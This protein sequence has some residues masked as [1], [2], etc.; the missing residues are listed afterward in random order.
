MATQEYLFLI[1][2]Y[3]IFWQTNVTIL[4]PQ[5][6]QKHELGVKPQHKLNSLKLTIKK[7]TNK[8]CFNI[9]QTRL[10]LDNSTVFG[11]HNVIIW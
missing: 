5:I 2:L 8:T 3:E 1:Y 11:E 7:I 4:T 9:T 10:R 6:E